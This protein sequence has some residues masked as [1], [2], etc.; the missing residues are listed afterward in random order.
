MCLP[1]RDD[2]YCARRH[3]F[4]TGARPSDAVKAGWRVTDAPSIKDGSSSCGKLNISHVR[5]RVIGPHGQRQR[6]R[7]AGDD[8]ISGQFDLALQPRGAYEQQRHDRR[9]A[10]SRN[11]R[12]KNRPSYRPIWRRHPASGLDPQISPRTLRSGRSAATRR[13][14]WPSATAPEFARPR[15]E[16]H[17]FG[18]AGRAA[19]ERAHAQSG[20]G[21]VL[22]MTAVR[23]VCKAVL[24]RP[25]AIA[26]LNRT[27][28]LPRRV[29]EQLPLDSRSAGAG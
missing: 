3:C 18:A 20:A 9:Q 11:R 4:P 6:R 8:W 25:M 7:R 10:D 13:G 12:P 22:P 17:A 21:R 5:P 2:G 14:E 23:S 27:F 29:A 26:T 19:C 16:H 15:I 28:A 1:A 24:Q